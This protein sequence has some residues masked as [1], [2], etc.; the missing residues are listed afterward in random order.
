MNLDGNTIGILL[1]V[2]GLLWGLWEI[3]K[4]IP[5]PTNKAPTN[6]SIAETPIEEITNNNWLFFMRLLDQIETSKGEVRQHFID[7]G[8]AKLQSYREPPSDGNNSPN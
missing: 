6:D 1:I 7:A 2:V 3:F 8:V 5:S 4:K